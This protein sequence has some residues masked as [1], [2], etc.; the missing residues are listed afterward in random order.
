MD[1]I[2]IAF[3]ALL[4]LVSGALAALG[5]YIGRRVGKKRLRIGRLRP[6]HTAV[7][8]TF[9]AG[10]VGTLATILIIASLSDQ[11]ETWLR[12]G[13]RVQRELAQSKEELADAK[14]EV[15]SAESEIDSVRSELAEETEKLRQEQRNVALA[16]AEAERLHAEVERLRLDVQE[17]GVL[18]ASSQ[19]ALLTLKVEFNDLTSESEIL[20]GNIKEFQDQQAELNDE[21]IRLRDV[22]ASLEMQ[23]DNLGKEISGLE[24]ETAQLEEA[25]QVASD[26]FEGELAR[27]ESDRQAALQKLGD[28]EK[29]LRDAERELVDLQNLANAL[30]AQSNQAR[31]SP[32][33]YNRKDEICRIPVRSL[34]TRAEARNFI[35]A[36]LG[37]ATR[38]AR[39]RGAIKNRLTGSEADFWL[40]E[41]QTKETLFDQAVE[42]LMGKNF[43]QIVVAH[44]PFNAF[45]GE[46]VPLIV[47]IW[48]N[49]IVYEAGDVIAQT[50]IDGSKGI[51]SATEQ[52][53]EFLQTKLSQA[54]LQDGMIPAIGQPQ[55][56]GEV[57]QEDLQNLIGDITRAGRNV[58]VSV[59]AARQTR[60]GDPL[61]VEFQ[62]S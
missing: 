36:L 44:A 27:I 37:N 6:K 61:Q 1:P 2:T 13:I 33:I 16:K 62:I 10:M 50:T 49:P 9:L 28:A 43:E 23:V 59:V 46:W 5:D 18:L 19:K 22:N 58:T 21:N 26:R 39:Q 8:F 4:V 7:L 52:L 38:V 30:L 48:P 14:K 11:V 60:A 41:G 29:E 25:Q 32:L 31:V 35:L 54:A 45:R 40:A 34:L 3:V 15:A 55:P 57:P 56:L 17:L 53:V 24:R 47:S 12:D 20:K 42:R 51:Q